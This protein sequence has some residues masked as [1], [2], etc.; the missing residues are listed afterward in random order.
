MAR[1]MWYQV[2][3]HSNGLLFRLI[4]LDTFCIFYPARHDVPWDIYLFRKNKPKL[5]TVRTSFKIQSL[6]SLIM[7]KKK[8]GE[9]KSQH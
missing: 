7:I 9:I 4:P 6:L 8:V 1:C 3:V 5:I 2:A